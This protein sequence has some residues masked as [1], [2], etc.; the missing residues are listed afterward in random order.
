TFEC[1]IRIGDRTPGSLWLWVDEISRTLV[2]VRVVMAWIATHV[3]AIVLTV[4]AAVVTC[5]VGS[6]STV[7]STTMPVLHMPGI[8]CLIS[9]LFCVGICH[10]IMN[11][12][13]NLLESACLLDLLLRFLSIDSE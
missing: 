9:K 4:S 10:G 8:S 7:V 11:L 5:G 13:S 1:V 12:R 2:T 3:A 6:W